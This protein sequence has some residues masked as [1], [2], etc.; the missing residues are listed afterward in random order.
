MS[1]WLYQKSLPKP[2][3]LRALRSAAQMGLEGLELKNYKDLKDF[4]NPQ[5]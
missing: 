3:Q 2:W 5:W 1:S 4:S